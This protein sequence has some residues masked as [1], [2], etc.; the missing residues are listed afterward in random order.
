MIAGTGE[1]RYYR[2]VL[3]RHPV[4]KGV[5]GRAGN[6]GVFRWRALR[7]DLRGLEGHFSDRPLQSE[8]GQRLL[9][10]GKEV[11][12]TD[13]GQGRREEMGTENVMMQTTIPDLFLCGSVLDGAFS[14]QGT[15]PY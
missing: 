10:N 9:R 11:S 13:Q 1:K 6:R 4:L 5:G 15:W 7:D 14:D 2:G 3:E 8:K 12:V